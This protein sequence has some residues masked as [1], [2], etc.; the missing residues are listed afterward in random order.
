[1]ARFFVEMIRSY[2]A[3]IEVEADSA[4]EACDMISNGDFSQEVQGTYDERLD[5]VDI[6]HVRVFGTYD[7][8]EDEYNTDEPVAEWDCNDI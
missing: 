7:D 4:Q 6:T 1:M 2:E 3:Y 5:E 8:D